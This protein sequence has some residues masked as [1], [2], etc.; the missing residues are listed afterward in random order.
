MEEKT[1]VA[2]LRSFGLIVGGIFALLGLWPLV[3]HAQEVRVWAMALAGILVIP[4]VVFPRS[5]GLVYRGWMI[6]G[7]GLGWVNTKIILGAIFYA[8]F[9]PVAVVLRFRGKDPMTRKFDSTMQS[10][11][12]VRGS[13]PG[14]H[15]KRQF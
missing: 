6:L 1:S 12:V 10:Y 5:L 3:F 8:L 7:R 11:R 15:L 4:A 14:T 2:Q 13:R 9:T